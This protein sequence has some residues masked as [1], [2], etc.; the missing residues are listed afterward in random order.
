MFRG[1]TK[2]NLDSKGRIAVPS[3]YRNALRETCDGETVITIDTDEKCLN[4]YPLP[5]WQEI[6]TKIDALPSMNRTAK[7]IKRMLI[8]HATDVRMDSNGRLLVSPELRDFAGL[9]KSVVLLGQGKKFELWDEAA[10]NAELEDYLETPGEEEMPEELKT[11][12]L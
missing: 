11:L 8:G 12:S 9:N 2:L 6:E 1:I 7:R 4:I 10:W 5:T 3:R